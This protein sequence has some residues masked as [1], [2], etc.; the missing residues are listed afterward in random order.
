MH[1]ALGC[2]EHTRER[3]ESE[4]STLPLPPAPSLPLLVLL[5]PILRAPSSS[6][7]ES[8]VPSGGVGALPEGTARGAERWRCPFTCRVR[9]K[10]QA[11]AHRVQRA[12]VGSKYHGQ[13]QRRLRHELRR[14]A[15]HAT[16]ERW[17][18]TSLAVGGAAAEE[19]AGGRAFF[20]GARDMTLAFKLTTL[21]TL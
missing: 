19:E 9:E 1:S 13:P 2:V 10:H 7:F 6:G 18:A 5:L 15:H 3:C 20:G 14:A 11:R 12:C 17:A 21:A 8:A 4:A 16:F